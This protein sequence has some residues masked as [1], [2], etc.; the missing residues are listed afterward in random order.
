MR[1]QFGLFEGLLLALRCLVPGVYFTLTLFAQDQLRAAGPD[2]LAHAKVIV[3]LQG[4]ANNSSGD[5]SIQGDALVF[6]RRE[7]PV[8]QVPIRSIQYFSVTQED[9]QVGGPTMALTR[10]AVPFGGGRVI[11]M[12]SH[13]KYDFVTLEYLDSNGGFHGAIYQLNKGEAQ[14]LARA[15]ENQGV[16]VNSVAIDIRKDKKESRNA[17]K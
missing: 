8:T 14:N 5:L 6:A 13:K 4:I 10:A 9:K 7:G 15:L 11:G 3:G 17:F 2:G 1:Y 12:F 16:R